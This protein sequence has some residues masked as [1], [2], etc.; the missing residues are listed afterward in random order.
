MKIESFLNNRDP[1]DMA[2]VLSNVYLALTEDEADELIGA[3]EDMRQAPERGPN[4]HYHLLAQDMQEIT[5]WLL[6]TDQ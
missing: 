2:T 3:L 5:V 1:D 6:P 4:S